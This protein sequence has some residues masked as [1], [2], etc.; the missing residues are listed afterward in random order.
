MSMNFDFSEEQ[1]MI[2]NSAKEIAEAFGPEY[3]REAVKK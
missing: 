3:W 2:A 1:K